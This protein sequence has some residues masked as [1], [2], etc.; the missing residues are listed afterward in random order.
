MSCG[1]IWST[2][3]WL[4][5]VIEC[6]FPGFPFE[7]GK[8]MGSCN[9]SLPRGTSGGSCPTSPHLLFLT[10]H[11]LL[12]WRFQFLCSS[13]WYCCKLSGHNSYRI[14]PKPRVESLGG[15][16]DP[17]VASG[18]EPTAWKYNSPTRMRGTTSYG[19]WADISMNKKTSVDNI[20]NGYHQQLWREATRN[21]SSITNKWLCLKIVYP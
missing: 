12:P 13:H 18:I 15:Y 19:L 5:Q 17:L 4:G 10:L 20:Y 7:V 14:Y 6:W 9:F 3:S 21:S 16:G 2:E 11:L 1:D 8:P